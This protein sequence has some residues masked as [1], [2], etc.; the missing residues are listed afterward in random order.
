MN[1]VLEHYL[2]LFD[3]DFST[4]TKK[5][6]KP[7][8]FQALRDSRLLPPPPEKRTYK[9]VPK[10]KTGWADKVLNSDNFAVKPV[11]DWNRRDLR[12]YISK[13]YN[14][15]W[16]DT[17]RGNAQ[18]ALCNEIVAKVENC[19]RVQLKQEGYGILKEY[20][21]FFIDTQV[22][23]AANTPGGMT[24]NCFSWDR[25]IMAFVKKWKASHLNS[26]APKAVASTTHVEI[27]D[28]KPPATTV[29]TKEAVE[30]AYK[31][32]PQVFVREYG[33]LIP[34]NYLVMVRKQNVDKALEY[35]RNAVRKITSPAAVQEVI[36][37]TERYTPYPKWLAFTDF[38]GVLTAASFHDMPNITFADDA[39]QF[40]FLRESA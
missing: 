37:A 36:E 13:T 17:L 21:D 22:E 4:V 32:T 14:V 15:R 38:N 9:K 31:I 28:D 30:T 5:P 10:T 12:Q 23:F 26:P 24:W 35:V 6:T 34:V 27:V 29:L 2:A 1:A 40:G 3:E 19:L 33:L 18:H 25:F 20:F 39:E 11:S 16:G 8:P 7:D